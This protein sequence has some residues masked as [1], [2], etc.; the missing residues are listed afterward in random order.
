MLIRLFSKLLGLALILTSNQFLEA[1]ITDVIVT[2]RAASCRSGCD[3][4]L[5]QQFG[6]VYGIYSTDINLNAGQANIKWKPNVA[7][8]F[9]P[10]DTAMRLVG[11]HINNVRLKVRGNIRHDPKNV[12][13]ISEGDGTEFYLLSPVTPVANQY[14]PTTS[15]YNREL[16]PEVRDQL[17][18]AEA[19]KLNVIIEGPLFQ[20]YRSP[21]LQ[22]V[23][24]RI[25]LEEKK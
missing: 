11:P 19:K 1:E 6:K 4:L 20:P 3:K 7:F 16:N 2:W 25:N 5:M 12:K 10:L 15:I 22:L 13:L 14:T 24:E 9:Q 8:S 23:I 17:L 18:D 21:P